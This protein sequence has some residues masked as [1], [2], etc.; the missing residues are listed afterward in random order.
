[1]MPL[2]DYFQTGLSHSKRKEVATR[3]NQMS[4]WLLSFVVR[5]AKDSVEQAMTYIVRYM[6]LLK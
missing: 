5:K 4:C 3:H 2:S 6:E 1:M